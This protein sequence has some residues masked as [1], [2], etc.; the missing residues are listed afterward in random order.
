LTG[1]SAKVQAT[2]IKN[3]AVKKVGALIFAVGLLVVS[4]CSTTRQPAALDAKT[5]P[6]AG[7]EILDAPGA[8][9]LL[10]RLVGKWVLSGTM[11]GKET[12]HDIDVEWILNRE[13]VRLHELSRDRK[14]DGKP[15][16]EAIVLIGWNQRS[17]D[18]SCLWLDSTVGGGLSANTIIGHAKPSGDTI[19]FVFKF[20]GG[21]NFHT[22]FIY[23]ATT[24]TWQLMMDDEEGGKVQ[25]FARAR[26]TRS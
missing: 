9:A 14:A 15:A 18:F 25:P 23:A 3:H 10:D 2:R 11:D 17:R 19:P 6:G 4:G 1:S 12:T 7:T 5:G 21:N 24:G 8:E 20:A 16:Y 26:L 22:T 13:Y